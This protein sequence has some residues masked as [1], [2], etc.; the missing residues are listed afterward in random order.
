[1]TMARNNSKPICRQ[2]LTSKDNGGLTNYI[3]CTAPAGGVVKLKRASSKHRAAKN[4][5]GSFVSEIY[6]AVRGAAGGR[7]FATD[8][9]LVQGIDFWDARREI[10]G[11]RA[12]F[13]Q[14]ADGTEELNHI[15]TK[16]RPEEKWRLGARSRFT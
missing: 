15:A 1:M 7:I 11:G 4:T 8:I 14:P 5:D 13:P 16:D 2:A 12:N 3:S 6:D 10:C 9:S